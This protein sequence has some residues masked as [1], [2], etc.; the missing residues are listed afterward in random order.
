[1]VE[2]VS[3]GLRVVVWGRV[4]AFV[5]IGPTSLEKESRNKPSKSSKSSTGFTAGLSTAKLLVEGL[6]AK[7]LGDVAVAD[8]V[9]VAISKLVESPNNAS[10]SSKFMSSESMSC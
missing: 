7:E 9:A 3:L 1:M 6:L 5:F 10:N 2:S 8:A 4:G